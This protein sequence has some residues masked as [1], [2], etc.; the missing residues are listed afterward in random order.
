MEVLTYLWRIG[1]GRS[2]VRPTKFVFFKCASLILMH[3]VVGP[4][5]EN[6]S[7]RVCFFEHLLNRWVHCG[8]GRVRSRQQEAKTLFPW[9]KR[10]RFYCLV[11]GKFKVSFW[12]RSTRA[13]D[14]N[15]LGHWDFSFLVTSPCLLL[16]QWDGAVA[17][18]TA[19]FLIHIQH[20]LPLIPLTLSDVSHLVGQNWVTGLS[21]SYWWRKIA[22]P[23]LILT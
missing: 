15:L 17:I 6:I 9:V 19:R 5:W 16:T 4:H 3:V 23:G 8:P 12:C 7:F 22:L 18:G 10:K 11:R 21:L 1:L 14:L 20:S 13:P 2:N